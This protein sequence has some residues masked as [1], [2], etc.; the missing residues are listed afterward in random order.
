MAPTYAVPGLFAVTEILLSH[1][2]ICF[3]SAILLKP[4]DFQFFVLS[5]RDTEKIRYFVRQ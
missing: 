1:E 3:I 2:E 5:C 4:Q